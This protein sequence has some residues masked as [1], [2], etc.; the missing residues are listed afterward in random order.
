MT[1][2]TKK[3][4][5]SI[6]I[7]LVIIIGI[8]YCLYTGVRTTANPMGIY[9]AQ[10]KATDSTSTDMIIVFDSSDK[11]NKRIEMYSAEYYDVASVEDGYMPVGYIKA[12]YSLAAHEK[13][14]V[15]GGL[16]YDPVIKQYY[17]GESGDNIISGS[18]NN[19]HALSK[20]MF[21][22]DLE[23][24]M[25]DKIDSFTVIFYGNKM[26][27]DLYG[28]I[29]FEKI[30]TIPEAYADLFYGSDFDF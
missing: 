17:K 3:I 2:R 7:V 16:Y 21:Y 25:P 22:Q 5:L 15:I 1:E 13:N 23:N 29:V 4:L 19:G 11:N 6:V 26:I 10:I 28:N 30:D 8:K 20:D 14:H 27:T 24:T 9:M 18:L 12:T